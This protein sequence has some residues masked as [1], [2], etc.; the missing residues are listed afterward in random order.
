MQSFS[1]IPGP[2]LALRSNRIALHI[3]VLEILECSN[4]QKPRH[5]KTRISE[6]IHNPKQNET[7]QNKTKQC[8]ETD[9]KIII[10]FAKDVPKYVHECVQRAT[11]GGGDG[12]KSA[13]FRIE[14][15]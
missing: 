8:D 9:A 3:T 2:R 10:V 14:F 1:H 7:K 5:G 13:G 11:E 6:G 12:G 15:D 4:K